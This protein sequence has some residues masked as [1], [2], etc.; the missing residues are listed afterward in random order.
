MLLWQ[1]QPLQLKPLS[2]AAFQKELK[3]KAPFSNN[4]V[5]SDG[6]ISALLCTVI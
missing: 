4:E 6:L 1:Q 2:R 5:A 3:N